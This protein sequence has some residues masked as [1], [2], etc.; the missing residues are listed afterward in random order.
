MNR[1]VFKLIPFVIFLVLS[2]F[3]YRGLS[4][5]PRELP[6]AIVGKTIPSF[7]LPN[8]DEGGLDLSNKNMPH[9]VFLLNV[10]A[11]W[12]EAC[13]EEQ[14][15]LMK[16]AGGDI[17]IVGINYKDEQQSALQWLQEWGNP[18]VF[19]GMDQNGRFAIELGVYGSPETFLV[20]ENGQILHRHTGVLNQAVWD[21]EFRPLLT[22]KGIKA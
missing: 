22:Q 11:S 1:V 10:W 5:D 20:D 14:V 16:L 19:C 18:Y 12:C 15:F 13:I 2:V 7:S 3:L 6:S 4:L 9:K 17:P 8:L 21:T